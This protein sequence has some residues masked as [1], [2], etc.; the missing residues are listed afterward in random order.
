MKRYL[1]ISLLLILVLIV[2]GCG[3][4]K[5]I[6]REKTTSS[7]TVV[8]PTSNP[9][10]DPQEDPKEDPVSKIIF[11]DNFESNESVKGWT[12]T[13]FWHRQ[14]NNSTIVNKAVPKYVNLPAGD[15]S[16]GKIPSAFQGNYCYWYGQITTG[17]YIGEQNVNDKNGSGGKSVKEHSG[18]LTSPAITIPEGA[19]PVL[20]F[21]TWYEIEGFNPSKYDL[22]SIKIS[23]D[24]GKNYKEIDRLN[25]KVDPAETSEDKRKPIAYT[26]GGFNVP[27][28]WIEINLNLSEYQGKTIKIQFE[29]ST[30]DSMYN[31][32]RGWLIDQVKIENSDAPLLKIQGMQ[33]VISYP[34]SEKLPPRRD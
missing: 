2:T 15:T 3:G 7:K 5:R 34:Y 11:F 9:T 10:V 12:T 16:G 17:N 28:K 14:V 24:D 8:D 29:F 6:V 23:D 20:S 30:R 1:G 32:F 13:G 33:S 19:N 22:M 26:S 25:P 31:G 27:G 4:N 21:M 18:T